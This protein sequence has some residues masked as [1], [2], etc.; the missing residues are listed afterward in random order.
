LLWS[1]ISLC[2]AAIYEAIT[3]LEVRGATPLLELSIAAHCFIGCAC[4]TLIMIMTTVDR[5]ERRFAQSRANRVRAPN[6]LL[7]SRLVLVSI[8]LVCGVA[9]AFASSHIYFN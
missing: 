8:G 7:R 6:T 9:V 5:E 2:A 3:L 1:A 4:A